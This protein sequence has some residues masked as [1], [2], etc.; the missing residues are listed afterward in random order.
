MQTLFT[1]RMKR[2]ACFTAI[3]MSALWATNAQANCGTATALKLGTAAPK[4]NVPLLPFVPTGEASLFNSIVG[5]WMTT[6]TSGGQVVDS[7]FDQW[8]AD[9][10]EILNDT[11]P[12][13]TGNVFLGFGR[14]PA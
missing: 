8:N 12:P 3:A 4:A 9:G 1:A 2:L 7:G 11:P 14:R 5:L 13:A 10:T 6:F